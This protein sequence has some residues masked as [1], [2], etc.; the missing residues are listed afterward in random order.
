MASAQPESLPGFRYHWEYVL[1]TGVLAGVVA[2]IASDLSGLKPQRYTQFIVGDL[3]WNLGAKQPD[4]ILLLSLVVS[5][6]L[7]YAG[8]YAL[9]NVIRQRNGSLAETALRQLLIFSLMPLG[10]LLGKIVVSAKNFT[11]LDAEIEFLAGSLFLML[12]TIGLAIVL[13]LKRVSVLTEQD[14]IE[15]I[16]G[17][18][19]FVVFSF[20]AG[21]ALSLAIGRLHSAW[22]LT[23]KGNVALV[24]GVGALLLWLPLLK[25]WLER[26]DSL[27]HFRSKLRGL[28]WAVQGSFPLL[29]LVLVPLP[30]INGKEAFYGYPTAPA[31]FILLGGCI[32]IA[33]IDWVRRFKPPNESDQVNTVFTAIAP[34]GLIALLL[35]IKTPQVNVGAALPDDYHWGETLLPWWLWQN[36]HY[37]PFWDYEPSRGLV[38]YMTGLLAHL[39]FD[40]TAIA[41]QIVNLSGLVILPYLSLSF[42]VLARTIGIM[43]AFLAS[44]L[45]SASNG[46][47]E[48]DCMVTVVLCLSGRAF[49]KRP[50]TQWLI[51]WGTASLAL[52][53]FAPGQGGLLIL[54]ML[55][56]VGFALVRAAFK[57]RRQLLI[58]ATTGLLIL[59][60]VSLVTPLGKMLLGAVRYG[61]EQSSINSVAN[62]IAW[63]RSAGSN[64]MLSYPLWEVIRIAW[65]LVGLTAGLL[66]FRAVVDKA[67]VERQRYVTFGLPIFL[68]MVFFIPRA[69]GRIDPGLL[70]RLGAASEWAVCLLLPIVLICGFE[71]QKKAVSLLL[72]AVLGGIVVGIPAPDSLLAK[73]TRT[74]DVSAVSK[75][76]AA[77]LGLPNLVHNFIEPAQADRLQAIKQVLNAV[78]DPGETYLDL[79]NRSADYFY[80][81]YPPPIQ[82]GAVYNMPHRNQQL[83][84]LQK[85]E[86][87][88]PP[89][90]LASADNLLLDGGTVA[91]RAHL[92]YRYIVERY[93][94]I[95]VDKYIYMVRP[96]RLERL[97]TRLASVATNSNIEV[98]DTQ[99]A[100][101]TLLDQVFLVDNLQKIPRSWGLSF[102]SLQTTVQPVKTLDATSI[103]TQ[104]AVKK[105]GQTTYRITGKDP[106]ITFNVENLNLNGRDAGILAFDFSGDRH[107]ALA[108]VQI[109]WESRANDPPGTINRVSFS[110][111]NGKV[112]VPLDAAP[113]WLFAEGVKTI[114]VAI[115][116]PVPYRTFTLSN[117]AL[118]QRA[119]LQKQ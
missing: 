97:K 110:V 9:A 21:I 72:V 43:P 93:T 90:I 12:V 100:R 45:M 112:L 20:F 39:F 55:P 2:V 118:F 53:L 106:F 68:L 17:S 66:L 52:L 13:A 40:G 60:L 116:E 23:E 48:I 96:D 29:F 111:K 22:Q 8:F 69:A 42:L 114:R 31:L 98:G 38:N 57:E 44:L 4:Y 59:L 46:L 63:S 101:L 83:R 81:G 85:L 36:F 30:W 73:P 99:A 91:L 95:A 64:S 104:Q 51:G 82:A 26:F 1:A 103:E 61:V 5:F 119:E 56:L 71:Q 41:H 62:G 14:Y 7:I 74:I 76:S 18:L 10:I 86:V 84:A 102:E 16:G 28:L 24:A 34:I 54:A 115:V 27:G 92:L 58:A 78:V 65:V 88:P 15:A 47:A 79:T 77:R 35:Y 37:I 80:L 25:L 113:R 70:S 6:F 11:L 33:Y 19:L 107:N 75:M 87:T 32:A 94:P 49:L 109:D 89:I 105:I 108:T 50:W 3:A 117:V 67:W